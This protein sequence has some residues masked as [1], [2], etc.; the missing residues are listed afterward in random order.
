MVFFDEVIHQNDWSYE[1]LTEDGFRK[2]IKI[3][4]A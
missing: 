1:G 2:L 3:I 4:V